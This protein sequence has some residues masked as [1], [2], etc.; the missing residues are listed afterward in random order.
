MKQLLL[1][2]LLPLFTWA[3]IGIYTQED[4][5]NAFASAFPDQNPELEITNGDEED[6]FA[7]QAHYWLRAYANMAA[8]YKDEKYINR[9]FE[10]ID[11]IFANTDSSRLANGSISA[12]DISYE[13]SPLPYYQAYYCSK[14]N[15]SDNC[16]AIDTA[17]NSW[18]S[19]GWRR[20][21]NGQYRVEVLNDGMI[22]QGIVR[23]LSVVL[24]YNEFASFHELA[25]SYFPAINKIITMHNQNYLLHRQ[26]NVSGSYYYTR[27]SD[28]FADWSNPEEDRL[29]SSPVPYNHSATFG[30][31]L[32]L[33]DSLQGGVPEYRAKADSILAYLKNYWRYDNGVLQ[34]DYA[35]NTPSVGGIEDFGHGH[36]DVG[37]LY[38]QYIRGGNISLNE[39]NAIAAIIPEKVYAGNGELYVEIDGSGGI[40]PNYKNCEIG[41]DWLDYS[42]FNEQIMDIAEEVFNKYHTTPSWSRP[43]LGWSRIQYWKAASDDIITSSISS[44]TSTYEARINW[45]ANWQLLSSITPSLKQG[46]HWNVY[47]LQG[48]QVLSQQSLSQLIHKIPENGIFL[49]NDTNSQQT[50]MIRILP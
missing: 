21:F 34:W 17:I 9:G 49:L 7:W 44:K 13:E 40:A 27:T 23:F 22:L 31:V 46:S 20:M 26:N 48:K 25:Q 32:L 28:P 35:P 33:M 30:S 37:F 42:E 16:S 4:W 19:P 18:I 3:Q 24:A 14:V 39:M 47:N 5:D 15:Y 41:Y 1:F 36:I 38:L 12:N 2:I 29:Y 6:R 8:I 43:F 50:F 10:L 11:H 45:P